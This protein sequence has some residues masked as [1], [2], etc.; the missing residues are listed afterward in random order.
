MLKDRCKPKILATDVVA[1]SHVFDIERVHLKFGNGVERY[2]ERMKGRSTG[3]VMIVPLLD[4]KTLLLASEYAVG[5]EQYEL[6]FPKGMVDRGESA[7]DAANRELQEEVG[8][9]ARELIPLKHLAL[10]PGYFP[11]QMSIFLARDLYES[12]LQGDEPEPVELV[13]HPLDDLD[14]LLSNPLFSDARSV[15]ALFLMRTYLQLGY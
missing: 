8:Y 4:D 7:V 1:S 2:Y 15:A 6:T 12:H 3:A 5:T 9:A 14:G 13:K 10:S 11:S